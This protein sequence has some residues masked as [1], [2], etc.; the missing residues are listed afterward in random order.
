MVHGQWTAEEASQ[1][2]MWRE[3]TAVFRVLEAVSEKLSCARVRWFSDN[4]NVVRIL[5]VGSRKTHL[6]VAALKIFSLSPCSLVK[7]EAE[8][9][10]RE[11]NV[12]ADLLS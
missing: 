11:R 5:Y 1:S 2:S 6:Q 10:P 4:Q 8:W 7:I 3:L 9:I 12:R